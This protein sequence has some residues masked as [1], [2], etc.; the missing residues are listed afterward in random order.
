MD[1]DP[2]KDRLVSVFE[3]STS[4]Y[5]LFLGVLHVV[6]L[7]AW[8]VRRALRRFLSRTGSGATLEILDAGTGFGQFTTWLLRADP[9]VRITAVDIKEEYLA[10]L[11]K[12]LARTGFGGR[13]VVRY[14]DLTR[15]EETG[16]FD[17]VLSVD[18]MEHIEDDRGV[19][20][21]F[22]RVLRPGG[23]LIVNT[24]SDQGGSGVRQEG[25]SS[26]I[27]EHVRDG[28]APDEIRGKLKEAGL[29]TEDI[30]YT[31][32]VPGSLAW[33]LLISVPMRLMARSFALAPVVALWYVAALPVGLLLNALDLVRRHPRGTGLLVVARKPG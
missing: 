14:A 6:F 11:R 12:H 22:E 13:A 29:E 24:P 23:T 9:R 25:D 2:I 8:Y 20:R 30:L 3:R 16:P 26:F 33:R 15:L 5:R 10:R 4:G 7:R 17:L 19:F 21:H 27:G 1:Y 18:V 28:Y 32:G 31:Y